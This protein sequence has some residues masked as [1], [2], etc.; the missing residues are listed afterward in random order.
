MDV[1]I[2]EETIL[3]NERN[4]W[5]EEIFVSCSRFQ[6]DSFIGVTSSRWKDKEDSS[7]D[8]TSCFS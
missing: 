3:G 2:I 7:V 5:K 1:Q 8:T 6:S 4:D